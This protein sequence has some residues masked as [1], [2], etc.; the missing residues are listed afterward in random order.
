LGEVEIDVI[1]DVMELEGLGDGEG[2]LEVGASDGVEALGLVESS[3]VGVGQSDSPLVVY[4]FMDGEG[5]LV[6]LLRPRH[7]ALGQRGWCRCCC[8]AGYSFLVAY[9]FTDGEGFLEGF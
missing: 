9:A 7:T 3:D 4:A 1:Q 8:T 6:G 2:F 5:F